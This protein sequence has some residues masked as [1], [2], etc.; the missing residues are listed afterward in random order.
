MGIVFKLHFEQRT[1]N[2]SIDPECS[3]GCIGRNGE[4]LRQ[5][6]V[7]DRRSL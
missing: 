1:E 6:T 2:V 7:F 5:P 3:D 4:N